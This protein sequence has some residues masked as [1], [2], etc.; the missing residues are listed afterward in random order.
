ME[1][2]RI[3]RPWQ[4]KPQHKSYGHKYTKDERYHTARWRKDRKLF[5]IDNPICKGPD[6]ICQKQGRVTPATV[7]DHIV[8]VKK[9]GDF[10]DWTN[11][12]GLCKHCNAVKTAKDK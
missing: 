3:H 10:W 8:P 1:I 9:G 11:R 7:C 12:Q 2:K 6:S 5:L 4:P